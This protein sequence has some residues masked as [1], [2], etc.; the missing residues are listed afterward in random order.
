MLTLDLAIVTHRPEG[1]ERVARILLPSMPG[2]RYIVSWQ[3]HGNA[4]IPQV[5]QQREDV[6]V[7][8]HELPGI[9]SNRNNAID[10]CSADIVL[11]AD[12]DLIY[13]PEYFDNVRR[14]FEEHPEVDVAT[15]RS[16]RH[17]K[18]VYPADITLLR[19]PFPKGYSVSSLEIAFRRST[20][21]TLRCC[22]ELGLGAPRLHGGEDEIFLMTAIKRGLRCTF[23]PYIV[24]EHD[25]SSTGTK[26]RL[27]AGNLE[28]SG[29]VIALTNPATCVL[30]VPL[31]AW[32]VARSGQAPL[33]TALYHI[34]RG[35]IA[36]AGVR[37][38]N[39]STVM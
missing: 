20:A 32:R 22:T 36:A 21:G 29:C 7:H 10:H 25:H 23:F 3:N 6:E 15:F 5:L 4:P 2:V 13:H 16:I 37:R 33:L 26:A 18:P 27:T 9:S 8:R 35:A 17:R 19:Q 24:C 39:P 31:K 34:T 28:A 11:F 38:R 14:A 12:D 1:I 30:R